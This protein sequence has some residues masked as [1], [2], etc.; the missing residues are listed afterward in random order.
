MSASKKKITGFFIITIFAALLGIFSLKSG[1]LSSYENH[2]W[3]RR[4][5][6]V[7]R[8][9]YHDPDIK[10]IIIDQQ[11][12]DYFNKHESIRWPFP[13]ALYVPVIKFLERAGAR[14]VAFD[15]L[16]TEPSVYGADDDNEFARASAAKIP[17]VHALALSRS[18]N[19]PDTEKLKLLKA[20]TSVNQSSELS[21]L[22]E[23][24]KAPHYNSAVLPVKPLLKNTRYF[25]SV[26]AAPDSDGIFRHYRPGGFLQ[27]IPVGTLPFAL[28]ATSAG[29][30]WQKKIARF[31]DASGNLTVKFYGG[32]KTFHTDNIV[33]IINSE[34]ALEQGRKPIVDPL[35]YK[36]SW[37][38]VGVWAPGLLDLRPV[39]V[40]RAYRGVEFNATVLNNIIKRDFF[41]K[42]P[43][44]LNYVF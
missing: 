17:V 28:Y 9:T 42:L 24:I 23:K 1:F 34:I 43:A 22:L 29:S 37:V 41:I 25:G 8:E 38:F 15:I 11:S 18:D 12:L 6:F 16:Y 36:D 39:A 10:I 35:Q 33:N 27:N 13:R 5:R 32:A 14:A 20:A 26:T 21:E 19:K 31:V 40:D 44:Y 4:V 2:T 30:G 3:D 7:A